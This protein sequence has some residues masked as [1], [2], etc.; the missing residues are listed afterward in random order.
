MNSR[1]G[2]V[3][4]ADGR[5][6]GDGIHGS[7]IHSVVERILR[8][9]S[10]YRQYNQ[11]AAL[12]RS[13]HGIPADVLSELLDSGIPHRV[14]GGTVYL[15]E[16]DLAN[17]SFQLALP[18]ARAMAQR[19]WVIALKS[20]RSAPGSAY[21]VTFRPRCPDS[22][23]SGTCNIGQPAEVAAALG[24]AAA[25]I[26]PAGVTI[27][28]VTGR[29]SML[30]PGLFHDLTAEM[31]G[32]DYHLLPAQL[33]EDIG[34]LRQA[35]LADCPLAAEYLLHAA[36]EHG[37]E[38]R[39]SFGV[40]VSIPFSI[41]HFWLELLIDGV[42]HAIDPHLI[43][44]LRLR[45]LVEPDEWPVHRTLGGAAWR[46]ADHDLPLALHNGVE[47]PCSLPTERARE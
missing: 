18:S 2:N 42:W 24:R 27:P 43:R 40:F 34:F 15:D 25:P 8:V 35:R 28:F 20:A 9:P 31:T 23:H 10:A 46:L 37:Y 29:S 22:G 4:V 7:T 3:P 45:G 12:A 13:A 38:A 44:M 41:P 14:T 5:R 16:L 33:H 21:E 26:P 32:I 47:I 36:I 1:E 6:P 11:S 39:K 17:A 30:L 19:S